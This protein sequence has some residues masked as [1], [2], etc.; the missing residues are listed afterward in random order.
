MNSISTK[1]TY[2]YDAYQKLVETLV[3]AKTTTGDNPS[4]DLI[5]LTKVNYQR[6][7]RAYQKTE[8][9]EK[10]RSA[11]SNIKEE[12]EWILISEPWC[13][14]SA[15]I[16]PVIARIAELAGKHVKLTIVLR[17]DGS[18]LIERY[19]TDGTRSIPKLIARNMDGDDLFTW[20]PRT[21]SAS[22]IAKEW[23]KVKDTVPK[24]TFLKNL[25]QWYAK[26]KGQE[27]HQE[28]AALLS[29]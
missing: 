18:G 24:S 11:F 7:I 29:Q 9:S 22:A 27:V 2:N 14:D 23:K 1:L 21:Q 26:D 3:E 25:H 17:D 28:I 19:L 4:Q 13:G 10:N 20:G 5:D 15:Q 16:V 12:Q 8:F 6:M